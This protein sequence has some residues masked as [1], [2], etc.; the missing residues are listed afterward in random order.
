MFQLQ[1]QMLPCSKALWE[2]VRFLPAGAQCP[3]AKEPELKQ[4]GRHRASPSQHPP[5]RNSS[6]CYWKDGAWGRSPPDLHKQG[7]LPAL[8]CWEDT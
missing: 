8:W 5:L 2:D 3:E 4:M 7:S 6:A 1:S